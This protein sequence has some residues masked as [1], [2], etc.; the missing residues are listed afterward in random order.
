MSS[1]PGNQSL[2]VVLPAPRVCERPAEAVP[3][4][5]VE[6]VKA[7]FIFRE[8]SKTFELVANWSSVETENAFYKLRVVNQNTTKDDI[9]AVRSVETVRTDT[10]TTVL[11]YTQSGYVQLTLTTIRQ[12]A[13]H[14]CLI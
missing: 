4:P 8:S 5:Q 2:L 11:I 7:E 6:D 13:C 12:F 9:S 1:K 14:L 3:P 10:T